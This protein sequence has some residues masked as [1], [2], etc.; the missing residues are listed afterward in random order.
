[1]QDQP[2]GDRQPSLSRASRSWTAIA[3]NKRTRDGHTCLFRVPQN[4]VVRIFRHS[5]HCCKALEQ[6]SPESHMIGRESGAL[7]EA[8][9]VFFNRELPCFQK[10]IFHEC[11]A[12]RSACPTQ[13]C[14]SS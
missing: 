3:L 4:A 13:T 5:C 6:A 10:Y 8:A 14:V 12:A 11:K 2:G 1:V 7:S 9:L